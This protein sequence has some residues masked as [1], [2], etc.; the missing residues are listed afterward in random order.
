MELIKSTEKKET[1]KLEGGIVN[2]GKTNS[3]ENM[4]LIKS[5]EKKETE[6]LEGGIVNEGKQIVQ[7]T[8]N[9]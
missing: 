4:E 3:A 9:S 8:W 6:K 2:E 1:E 5:T 7:R